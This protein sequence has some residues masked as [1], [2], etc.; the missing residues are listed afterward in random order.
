MRTKLIIKELSEY[1][2]TVKK[3]YRC[4][5]PADAK[6]KIKGSCKVYV[7]EPCLLYLLKDMARELE[8]DIA[9]GQ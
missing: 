7:C 5:C 9:H 1:K 6:F 8:E 4:K 2:K 3:C